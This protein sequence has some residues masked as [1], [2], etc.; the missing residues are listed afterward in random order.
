MQVANCGFDLPERRQFLGSL[1]HDGMVSI[2]SSFAGFPPNSSYVSYTRNTFITSSPRWLITFTAIRPLLGLSN[3]R[4]VS[5]CSVAQA[6][7]S[8]SAFKVVFSAL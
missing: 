3:G 5:L 7:R 6:S 4:E 1:D 8:I 2:S